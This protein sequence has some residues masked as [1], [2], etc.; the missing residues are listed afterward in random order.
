MSALLLLELVVLVASGV[1]AAAVGE[2]GV[3]ATAITVV[4][5]PGVS[6]AVFAN[7]SAVATNTVNGNSSAPAPLLLLFNRVADNQPQDWDPCVRAQLTADG[8]RVFAAHGYGS[9]DIGI[10]AYARW[11]R[12]EVLDLAQ[13]QADP[14]ERHLQFANLCPADL[15]G[16]TPGADPQY[17]WP[18]GN[19]GSSFPYGNPPY[20]FSTSSSGSSAQPGTR[21][22]PGTFTGWTGGGFAAGFLT[23]TSNWQ[24]AATMWYVK[25]GWKLVY[26]IVP[27]VAVPSVIAEVNLAEGIPSESPNRGKSW[28]WVQVSHFRHSPSATAGSRQPAQEPLPVAS[29]RARHQNADLALLNSEFSTQGVTTTRNLDEV[30]TLANALGV[31]VVFLS[32]VTGPG[33]NGYLTNVGDYEVNKAVWPNGLGEITERLAPHGLELGFH[34][35]S[36]GTSVCM[37]QMTGPD[38]PGQ[39]PGGPWYI[40]P[41]RLGSC[42]GNIMM[43]TLVS[44]SRPE[45]F[46]PQGI[47][48]RVWNP[49]ITAGT[50]PCHEKSGGGCGDVTRQPWPGPGGIAPLT[51]G[52]KARTCEAQCPKQPCCLPSNPLMLVNTSTGTASWSKLG[53]FR[54]GGAIEFGGG[55]SHGRLKHTAD[56]DF[57]TNSYFYN[58]TNEFTLQLTIHPT[59]LTTGRGAV[60]VIASKS[61]EWCLQISEDWTLQ[62]RVHLASGW[63]QANS[64]RVLRNDSSY[65]IKATHAGSLDTG[66]GTLK[67]FSC[68]LAKGASNVQ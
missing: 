16:T 19:P 18:G 36:S 27:E 43:D 23:I 30:I 53:R 41:S 62:W 42:K 59:G 44:R 24:M 61:G 52:E 21:H 9:V 39:P 47:T 68:E 12:F 51:P 28:L 57:R 5:A 34:M 10:V 65:T 4:A 17:P 64:T 13:W 56:Y 50:W 35:L 7:C 55:G 32:D 11:L 25:P 26:T 31:A 60:Q 48:S 2:T 67:I 6:L 14:V 15:C 45:L 66:Q 38:M 40:W 29:S 33:M 1:G 20:G 63:A 58:I 22:V 8:L 3:G 54:D 49:A 37:D 46:V